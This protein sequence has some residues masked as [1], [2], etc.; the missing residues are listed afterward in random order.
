MARVTT[1]AFLLLLAGAPG[2][3]WCQ[4]RPQRPTP[5]GIPSI[6][7]ACQLAGRVF[8]GDAMKAAEHLQV[9][10]LY[11]S[12]PADQAFTDSVGRFESRS[13]SPS[14]YTVEIIVEG[15]KPFTQQVDLSMMCRTELPTI[16]LEPEIRLAPQAEGATVSAAEMLIPAKARK[17][18][19]K[20]MQ[21]LHEKNRPDRSAKHFR[22]AISIHPDYE[23][24]Y[25]QL[26][27]VFAQQGNLDAAETNLVK[28]TEINKKNA[29]AFVLLGLVHAR[30]ERTTDSLRV[31][32]EAVR[33]DNSDWMGHYELGRALA[34][35]GLLD[36]A[37]KH[38]QKAHRLKP[39]T[40]GVHILLH[41]V[42]L[43]RRDLQTALAEAREFLEM[44]PQ[45]P[46][47][48]QMRRQEKSLL[49]MQAAGPQ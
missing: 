29:R 41:D 3:A 34:R 33:L 13:L 38:A 35:V 43:R 32:R 37:Y 25:M 28:C 8:Y 20:G 26:G 42:S 11:N 49:E 47:A 27:L 7:Q 12:V 1:A 17:A 22:E 36:D 30:Q 2:L 24:A 39:D 45:D 16:I 18:F 23:F 15:Y 9:R 10:I 19:Q 21:E 46:L 48:A 31:L 4:D 40:P 5:P 44:F 6:P 14:L